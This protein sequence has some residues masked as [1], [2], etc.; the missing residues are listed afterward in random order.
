LTSVIQPDLIRAIRQRIE[1]MPKKMNAKR[2]MT[3]SRIGLEESAGGMIFSGI[4]SGSVF[5][6]ILFYDITLRL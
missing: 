1:K 5:G 3:D 4:M 2:Q 6:S